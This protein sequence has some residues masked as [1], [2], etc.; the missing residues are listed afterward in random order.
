[1]LENV[2]KRYNMLEHVGNQGEKPPLK[3]KKIIKNP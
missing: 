2:G 3:I 1:M